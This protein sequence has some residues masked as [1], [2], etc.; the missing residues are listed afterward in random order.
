MKAKSQTRVIVG[1]SGGVDSSVVAYLLKK[2]GYDVVGV[3]MKNWDDTDDSGVC[4]ATQDYEDVAKV[5]NKIGI[6]YYSVNFEKEY[7]DRVFSYFLDEYRHGRT[8][9]PD[10]M[11]NKEIKFKA[12][13]DYAL[14]LDADYIAMGHYARLKRDA[15]GTVHLLRGA[16]GNKD[17]TYF[18]SQ[19]SQ[20]QL[21]KAM[22]P[23]GE[24]EKPEVRRLA[25]EAG[26]AT[27][28][29]KDSTG[30]CF[31]GERNFSKFLS[32]FLPAKAGL[33]KT[34]TGEV[35]G[36]HYGLMNYTIGQ[37][38]GLGI[39]GNGISN[40]PWFVIGKDLKSN[41][42]YVGQGYHNPHLYADMLDGSK[43]SFIAPIDQ[44]GREFHCTAKFR[45]R[46]K[47]C[48]V[49][50]KL[51]EDF[52]KVQVIF[53]QPARAVTPGQEVVFYDGAE[54]LG[55]ATIDHAYQKERVL[56]YV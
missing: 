7:W 1:M 30:V 48:G 10:V 43:V 20:Q 25:A 33:M 26:L 24:I 31:I 49:T 6:P 19:L 14:E 8:P 4:T 47:D 54:C 23:I 32:E 55:S 16:D 44:Y 17:Q 50:V 45:Y 5:A 52:Q 27:A 15:D 2:Q 41:T 22:F 3:F 12:F 13:L 51:S 11:C 46:Q 37:R 34:L 53:D 42:L 35:K 38:R 21:Q 56:Q 29:K 36:K 40:D 18:L 39:G 28:H 9:N